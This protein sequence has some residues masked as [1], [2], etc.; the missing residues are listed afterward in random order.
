MPK[1]LRHYDAEASLFLI[2]VYS[3]ARAISCEGMEVRDIKRVRITEID[4]VKILQVEVWKTKER[5]SEKE[6]K[7]ERKSKKRGGKR[8]KKTK[9]KREER[10]R[11]RENIVICL[12]FIVIS[13]VCQGGERNQG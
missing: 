8:E 2:G 12:F 13:V 11:R 4:G 5:T 1:Y 6:R 3:G 9:L 10:E 7:K